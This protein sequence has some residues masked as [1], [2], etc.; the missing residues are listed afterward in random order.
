[1][2]WGADVP[3]LSSVSSPENESTVPNY[4]SRVEVPEETFRTTFLKEYPNADLSGSPEQWFGVPS[5]SDAGKVLSLSIGGVSVTGRSIR[6]LFNLRSTAFSISF[7]G[8]TIVFSVTGYGHG[9]GMSQY[10]AQAMA[11]EKK[12][13]KEILHHYYQ[14]VEIESIDS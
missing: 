3:Y 2:V 4:E 7:E 5:R 10:G 12:S 14:N 1:M 11:L 8:D 6:S 9:V 13:Y